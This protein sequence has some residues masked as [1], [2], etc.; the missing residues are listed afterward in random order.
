M[1]VY[2]LTV[3]LNQRLFVIH[4][5]PMWF[6]GQL[7]TMTTNETIQLLKHYNKRSQATHLRHPGMGWSDKLIQFC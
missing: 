4:V 5:D 2:F 7:Q 3:E 6:R 1:H